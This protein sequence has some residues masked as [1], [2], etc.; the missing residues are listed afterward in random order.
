MNE[1]GRSGIEI[2]TD[3]Y[4]SSIDCVAVTADGISCLP[5]SGPIAT[6]IRIIEMLLGDA[7]L[8]IYAKHVLHL[9]Y[10]CIDLWSR[11]TPRERWTLPFYLVTARS[12]YATTDWTT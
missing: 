7:S 1:R 5:D 6:S 9:V 4:R 3:L 10:Q 11:L 8:L 12:N 2:R